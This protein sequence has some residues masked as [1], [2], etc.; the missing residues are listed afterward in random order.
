MKSK[1]AAFLMIIIVFYSY[2]FLANLP[3]GISYTGGELDV[4]TQKEPYSGRG[5]NVSSDAFALGEDVTLYALA[6]FNDWP[7]PDLLVT[8]HVAGPKNSM[9]N[10]TFSRVA[11]TNKSGIATITF[12][13]PLEEET[14]SGN[15]N[16][17]CNARISDE[18]INDY[19]TF[20]AGWIVEIVKL[21]TLDENLS[22]PQT[23]FTPNS[24]VGVKITLRNMAM[25]DKCIILHTS[26]YDSEG[27]LVDSNEIYNFTV[28]PNNTLI[29]VNFTLYIPLGV[30]AGNA[31]VRA[32]A[33]DAPVDE[34]GIAYCPEVSKEISI[35]VYDIAVISVVPSKSVIYIGETLEIQVTV[36]NFGNRE[37]SFDVSAY[38]N[39]TLIQTIS[40]EGLNA[41]QETTVLFQWHVYNV[42]KGKYVIS[43]SVSEV[44]GE[45]NLDN[46]WFTDGLVE[47]K[48]FI[49][50]IVHDVAVLNVSVSTTSVYKGEKLEVYVTVKNNGTETESFNVTLY[51][52]DSNVVDVLLVENLDAG[53]SFNLTFIW[54][55]SGVAV[56]NYTLKAEASVVEGENYTENNVFVDG[57]VEVKAAPIIE[58]SHDIAVVGV[59]VSPKTVTKGDIIIIKVTVKNEGD[60]SENFSLTIFYDETIIETRKVSSLGAGQEKLISFSWNTSNVNAGVYTIKAEASQVDGEKDLADNVFVDGTVEIVEGGEYRPPWPLWLLSFIIGLLALFGL[61]VLA[62]ILYRRKQLKKFRRAFYSGWQA[63]FYNYDL[64][65]RQSF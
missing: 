31:T 39:F 33:Y 26:L 40:V 65:G 52:D 21:E 29:Y 45:T 43:A 57:E 8:F 32:N 19:L 62:I 41:S 35:V 27:H 16:V 34:G 2:S 46:N 60:F 37:E 64:L 28:P 9:F 5:F 56:G 11:E 30:W 4:F 47:V 14:A 23:I 7:V 55:T 54:D 24:Y 49:A 48:E 51:Y 63:W 1:F 61:I 22:K 15:W 17:T 59:E 6:K 58:L 38:Y 20:Q 12:T 36:K 50:P 44:P 10:I 13:L 42:E 3:Q 53:K 25:T 18:I